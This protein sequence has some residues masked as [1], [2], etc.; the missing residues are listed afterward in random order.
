MVCFSK[1]W[2]CL[3]HRKA[4]FMVRQVVKSLLFVLEI[5]KH[6]NNLNAVIYLHIGGL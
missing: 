3:F 4:E 5:K 6:L 2:H 1:T